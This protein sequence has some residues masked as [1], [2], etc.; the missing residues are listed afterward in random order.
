MAQSKKMIIKVQNTGYDVGSAQIDLAIPLGGVG[1]FNAYS[2]QLGVS[3]SA[4]GE[5][6]GG[7]LKSC[8]LSLGT[9]AGAAQ[10]K[11]CVQ[12]YCD[13][14]FGSFPTHKAACYWFVNWYEVADNPSVSYQSVSCPQALNDGWSGRFSGGGGGGGGSTLPQAGVYYSV[15]Y[16]HSGKCQDVYGASQS[17]AANVVQWACHGGDNQKLLLEDRG[18]GY[19]ALKYK[20]SG[21][22]TDVYGAGQT[23]GANMIQ[24]GCHYNDNQLFSFVDRGG[25]WYALKYKH[26]GQCIDVYGGGTNDGAQVIQWPCHYNDNQL[27]KFVQ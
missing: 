16:K 22:C 7:A 11:S 1:L 8:Q 13:R 10:M 23:N 25:G 15:V 4:L 26:S 21:K 6:Y 27:F 18:G 9:G 12:G 20:H 14:L 24:W 3:A 19:Y 17:D 5:Q 2:S